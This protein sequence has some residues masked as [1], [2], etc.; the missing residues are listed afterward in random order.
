MRG[1]QGQTGTGRDEQGRAG[2]DRG[3]G[4]GRQGRTAGRTA[5]WAGTVLGDPLPPLSGDRQLLSRY[6]RLSGS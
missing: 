3:T 2:T 1:E 4:Q 5:G 6:A